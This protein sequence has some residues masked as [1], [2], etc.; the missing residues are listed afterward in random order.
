M[1]AR[2]VT[3]RSGGLP[4]RLLLRE[5]AERSRDLIYRYRLRPTRGF[6]YVNSAATRVTGYTP[7]DHY[8]DPDLG[9]KLVHPDDLAVLAAQTEGPP[10]TAPV[11]L[12]WIRKD[13]KV[14][15]TE[16]SNIPIYDAEGELVALEGIAR[17]IDDPTRAPGEAIRV[18]SGLRIDLAQQRVFVDGRSVHLTPSEFRLLVFFT[19]HPGEVISREQVMQHL[20]NSDHAGNAHTCETHVSALRRKIERDARFPERILTVRGR[21]YRFAPS[22]S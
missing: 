18:S 7:E 1:S 10:S 15:W 4:E 20:W 16:Q 11:Q 3:E 19:A 2:H 9:F 6:E 5:F 12:R 21:G 13:G 17:E 14:I 8:A 22:L